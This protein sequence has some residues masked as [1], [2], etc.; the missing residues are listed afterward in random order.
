MPPKKVGQRVDRESSIEKT[1][2]YEEF[3]KELAAYH[4]KRG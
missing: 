2:E 1:E 3:L 4:E